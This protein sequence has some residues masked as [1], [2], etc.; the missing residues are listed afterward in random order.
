MSRS[1]AVARTAGILLSLG[2]SALPARAQSTTDVRAVSFDSVEVLRGAQKA[3]RD[4]ERTRR[5]NLPP[6]PHDYRGRCDA[7]IGRFCYWYMPPGTELPPEPGGT[8]AARAELLDRLAEAARSLPGDGWIAGQHVRYLV[9]HG[10]PSQALAAARACRAEP[11]WCSALEG[12]ALHAQEEDGRADSVFV[13]V[14]ERMPASERCDWLD[15]SV[16]LDEQT[17][18]YAR[19]PCSARG[20]VNSRIWWLARPLYSRA[21]NDLR[22][23]HYARHVM[24]HLLAGADAYAMAWGDDTAELIL[25]YGWP[26]HWTRPSAPAGS[27]DSPGALGL[28]RTPSWWFFASPDVP[29]RWDLDREQARARYAPTWAKRFV[30]IPDAQIARFRRGDSVVTVAG[31]DVSADTALDRRIPRVRLA[32]GTD[33]ASPVIVGPPVTA[34]HGG[35]S[36]HSLDPPAV[37]SLE[38]LHEAS[39]WVGRLRTA[40][41][42]PTAWVTGRLSDL[43]LVSADAVRSGTL[44]SLTDAALPGATFLAGRPIG[45]Y[46]EWYERAAKGTVVTIEVRV[47]RVGG[48]GAPSPLGRSECV[49]PDKAAMAVQWRENVGDQPVLGRSIALDLTRLGPGRYLVAAS[50]EAGPEPTRCTAREVLVV[51]S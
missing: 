3:V 41:A 13:A 11:W 8:D 24:V 42:D 6:D 14:L 1:R 29:P 12:F 30:T 32:V 17:D 38:A 7:R 22:V 2:L 51:G 36:V 40:A 18:R 48:K 28:E 50:M 23:E 49:P 44:G 27:T 34:A 47:A 15:L 46:W 35:V 20:D 26:I 5:A 16:L 43:L 37:V 19:V 45:I 10:R 21:G 31:F 25:R 33:A 9:E 39:G 4:F